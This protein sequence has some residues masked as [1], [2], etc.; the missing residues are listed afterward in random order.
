MSLTP[1]EAGEK[2]KTCRLSPE[3]PRRLIFERQVLPLEE[4]DGT[5]TLMTSHP[6]DPYAVSLLAYLLQKE[7]VWEEADEKT[8]AKLIKEHYGVG[9]ATMHEMLGQEE[10]RDAAT[11]GSA[12]GEER[13]D[14]AEA[15]VIKFVNQVIAEAHHERA[16][17]IHFEP[18]ENSLRIRY[19]VDGVLHQVPLPPEAKRFENAIIS[20]VKVMSGMD[21]AEKRLPQDGRLQARVD[22]EDLDVRV[23]TIPSAHG[24]SVSLRLLTRQSLVIGLDQ[25]GFRADNEKRLQSLIQRPHGIILVTGPTGCGKSTTLYACL[26]AINREELRLI[27]LEDPIEYRLAGVNQVQVRP[28]IEFDF[29]KGLRH[30]LRQDPDVIMV[31]E[32]RDFET[33][34]IAIRASLTGHLVFSTLHTND[35]PGAITRLL[36]M[37]VEPFLVS[38]SLNLVVAQRLVR[39]I[40]SHCAAATTEP[41]GL[42]DAD[43]D[44]LQTQGVESHFVEARGCER[45][46]RFGYLGRTAIHEFMLMSDVIRPLVLSRASAGAI[47]AAA[48][49]EGMLTLRQDGLI[50]AAQ[51]LTTVDEVLRVAEEGD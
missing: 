12:A 30:I 16:T 36:D 11:G 40:C 20:R 39:R 1:T 2:L 15:S 28:E 7:I 31:G 18:M 41:A 35:A 3:F 33:A 43:R 23:S 37:G 51:G 14:E 32:I 13:F 4:T 8:V 17:D 25:L 29:A 46:S 24:E 45:C 47:G 48:M 49:K 19:R 34:E 22:G 10:W 42:T 26:S 44:F 21:I 27:T 5:V 9:A 38:S 50:K 6:R